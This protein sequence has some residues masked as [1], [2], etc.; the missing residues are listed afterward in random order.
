MMCTIGFVLGYATL[1]LY[2][3]YVFLKDAKIPSSISATVHSLGE[4]KWWIFTLVMFAVAFLIAPKLFTITSYFNVAFLAFMTVGGILGVGVEPL[5]K[6]EKNIIHY[7]SA[8]VMGVA[9]QA[10]VYKL[11]PM[12]MLMWTPYVVYTMYAENGKCNMFFAEMVMMTNLLISCL[13]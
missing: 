5:V 7:S 1:V 13:L 10:I 12:I 4:G 6:G 9:S 8:V 3:L 11:C 2:L